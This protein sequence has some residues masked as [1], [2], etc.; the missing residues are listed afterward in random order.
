MA[1]TAGLK[2]LEILERPGI[3]QAMETHMTALCEG[4]GS[5][6]RENGI[7]VYQT[8]A[9]SMACLFFTE[10]P[11]HCYADAKTSDT[12]RYAAWFH[13]MLER[14][15][16]FAPSQFEAAFVSTAHDSTVVSRTLDAARDVMERGI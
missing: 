16:Y 4:L 8:R 15:V 2:T 14:G 5:I 1:M 9:G 3:F 10:Q 11:V 12:R 6:A 13:A 7:P